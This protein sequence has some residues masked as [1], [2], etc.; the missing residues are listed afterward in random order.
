[1]MVAAVM[2]GLTAQAQQVKRDLQEVSMLRQL[3]EAAVQQLNQGLNGVQNARTKLSQAISERTDLPRRFTQDPMRTAILIGATDT[4]EAFAKGLRNLAVDDT[5]SILPGIEAQRGRLPL[6]VAGQILRAASEPDAA[7]VVRPGILVAT[8]AQALVT[9]PV[10][11]TVR[12]SG[13]LLD[14]GL[15]TILEPQE[16]TLFVFAG[17]AAVF[18]AAGEVLPAGSPVGLMGGQVALSDDIISQSGEITGSARPETLYIEVREGDGTV[19]PLTWFTTD[20]G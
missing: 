9:T 3:Q 6:P 15:V 4:L 17:L 7:G 5:G 20:K 14:Y 1:M 10:P 19:D 12:Y 13:P 2:P 16:D 11:A 18:G 8:R